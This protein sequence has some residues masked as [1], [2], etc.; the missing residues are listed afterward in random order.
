MQEVFVSIG[1]NV[2]R[3]K[4]IVHALELL[5]AQFGPL[6]LSSV[7]ESASVGFDGDPFFN[8]AV[9]FKS[10]AEP[11]QIVAKLREIEE[12]CGRDRAGEKFGPRTMDLDLLL[13]GDRIM[14]CGD[15]VL[16][17]EEIVT[18][19]FVLCPLA[20]IAGQRRHPINGETLAV[21]WEKLGESAGSLRKVD[22][23]A[24]GNDRD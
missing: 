2:H 18:R 3:E 5:R 12:Q 21:M 20:E 8:L 24:G 22:F 14:S 1:S 9:A 15:I 23:H 6:H 4:Y 7:Y 17:H 10:D 19:A 13:V 11:R 16:P